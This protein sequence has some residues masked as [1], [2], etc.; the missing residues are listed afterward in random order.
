[1]LNFFYNIDKYIF[2]ENDI[3]YRDP[4]N[5]KFLNKSLSILYF[6]L[7]IYILFMFVCYYFIFF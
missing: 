3:F 7:F 1:M 2:D 5:S 4:N 6:L